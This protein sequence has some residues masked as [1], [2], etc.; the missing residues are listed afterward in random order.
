MDQKT[1][2]N[3]HEALAGD[4]LQVAQQSEGANKAALD[5]VEKV[6]AALSERAASEAASVEAQQAVTALTREFR[7]L[8][9]R[10]QDVDR[11]LAQRGARLR[12]LQ[13]LQE[14]WEGFGEGAKAVLQGRLVG[15]L[16]GS[17]VTPVSQGIEVKPEFG[18][19]VDSLL[20][21]A[22]EAIQ[23]SDL[24]TARRIILQL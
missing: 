8:Q 1:S 23:V 12:L 14:R 10:L 4:L 2:I 13:Q 21:S 9:R 22:A 5:A 17:K 20:G 16:A 15:A 6:K 19:A 7:D 18:R 24:A 3:R 11:Q